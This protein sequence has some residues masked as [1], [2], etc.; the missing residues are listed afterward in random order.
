M[1]A[2]Q[3]DKEW[4]ERVA[5]IAAWTLIHANVLPGPL[6]ERAASIIAEEV[7]VRLCAGDRPPPS[8]PG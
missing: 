1:E 2:A 4:S 7:F 5:T 3:T 8:E 6:Q